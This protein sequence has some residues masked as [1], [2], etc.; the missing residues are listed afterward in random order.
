M[1]PAPKIGGSWLYC[2][3]CI[4]HRCRTLPQY[5]RHIVRRHPAVIGASIYTGPMKIWVGPSMV[6]PTA[7]QMWQ[8]LGMADGIAITRPKHPDDGKPIGNPR[9]S[10]T[11]QMSM[12]Y[13]EPTGWLPNE[14]QR[15]IIE[16]VRNA[17]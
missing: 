6:P 13:D 2:P 17:Q 10:V 14:R 3:M 11:V 12:H 7:Q 1:I 5:R 8:Y 9:G 16:A 15:R 4:R